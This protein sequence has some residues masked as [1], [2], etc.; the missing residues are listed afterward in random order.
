M[1]WKRN[2]TRTENSVYLEVGNE[3]N[4]YYLAGRWY[5]RAG[6]KRRVRGDNIAPA[7]IMEATVT[8]HP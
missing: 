3:E 7:A 8:S 4:K 6:D 5:R 2:T 1:C